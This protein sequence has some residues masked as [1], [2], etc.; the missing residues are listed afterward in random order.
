[1]KKE[2]FY[3]DLHVFYSRNDGFSVPIKMEADSKPTEE[4]IID[5]ALVNDLIDSEDAKMVDY[6]DDIEEDT[7]SDMGGK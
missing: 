3:F 1:M 4:Q 2:T 7:Y 6:V 5:F